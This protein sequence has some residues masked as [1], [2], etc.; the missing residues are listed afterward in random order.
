MEDGQYGIY[1][2][3]SGLIANLVPG[4]LTFR[5]PG[6]ENVTVYVSEG[7]LKVEN[8]SVLVLVD[9]LE[10]PEEIDLVRAK[11]A[12]ERAKE[13]ALQKK[14]AQDYRLAQAHMM[15]ALNRLRAGNLAA[16]KKGQK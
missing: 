13:E 3:H 16:A 5:V 11:L 15:R 2:H 1:A 6:E 14:S 4:Q 9:A 10:R 7:L 12:V 8:N